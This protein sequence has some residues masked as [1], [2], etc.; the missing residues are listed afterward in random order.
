MI[1]RQHRDK[2]IIDSFNIVCLE[3]I[4]EKFGK[5]IRNYYEEIFLQ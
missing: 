4:M 1:S 3:N 2:I 5:I